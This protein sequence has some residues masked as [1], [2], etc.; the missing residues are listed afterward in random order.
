MTR[1]LS[2]SLIML[3][4]ALAPLAAPVSANPPQ[5]G[6]QEPLTLE[7]NDNGTWIG[8]SHH[9]DPMTDGFMDAGTYEFRFTSMNLTSNDN[10]SL[11]W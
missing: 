4:S 11:E 1:T 10:Y 5:T 6:F 3:V 9:S 7:M 8:V 2:I